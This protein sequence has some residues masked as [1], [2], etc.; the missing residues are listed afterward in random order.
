MDQSRSNHTSS[1]TTF[2]GTTFR[3]NNGDSAHSNNNQ[4]NNFT[5]LD[6]DYNSHQGSAHDQ[7]QQGISSFSAGN[8]AQ[9]THQPQNIGA[10]DGKLDFSSPTAGVAR[11]PMLDDSIF[12]TWKDDSADAELES[13][14]EMQKKDPLAAQIWRFYSK[15]KKQ[16]PRQERM[17]NLTWRMMAM[18]MRKKKEEET[19]RYVS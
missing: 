18:S 3:G 14:D 5:T 12:P 9:Y 10:T 19:A 16:L 6:N 2:R 4:Y 17:E 8:D 1:S 11:K 15:Q 13:P 7:Q